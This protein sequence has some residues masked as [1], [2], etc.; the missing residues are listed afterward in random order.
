M[1]VF[2]FVIAIIVILIGVAMFFV[3]KIDTGTSYEKS[4][5]PW[6]AI[7]LVI[8]LILLLVASVYTQDPGEA[9]VIRSFSGKIT[10]TDVTPGLGFTPPWNERISFDIRN[11]RIE[12]FTNRGGQGKDGAMI[13]APLAGS[14]NAFV[15][16]TVRYSIKPD[17]IRRIYELHKSQENLLDN[18]LRPGLRDEVRVATSEFPPFQVK[19]RRA[20]LTETI[21]KQ[22]EARWAPMGVVIDDIDLG[23]LSLDDETEKALRLVNKRQADVESAR[24]DLERAY[25]EAET[26][27]TEAQAQ[28]DADQIIRCGAKTTSTPRE[29]AGK[30]EQVTVITPKEGDECENRLNE[31][32][33]TSKWF[34]TLEVLGKNGNTM[35]VIPQNGQ[36][37][38]IN[39][40]G[41]LPKS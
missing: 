41:A 9:I 29:I 34:D 28:A 24:A 23:D 1:S 4:L 13:T 20:E 14:S 32:V 38:I 15:S 35:V 10:G 16:I 3:N 25:I 19:E 2:I 6:S 33:L 37:P 18:V 11:Q 30:E 31:Q 17:S 21:R 39:L 26:T 8:G 40:P 5:R 36:V 7:P 12:M 22:L 27:K